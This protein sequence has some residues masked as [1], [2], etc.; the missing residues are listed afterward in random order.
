LEE[1]NRAALELMQ[2]YPEYFGEGS[3]EWKDGELILDETAMEEAK[4]AEREKVADAYAA[5]SMADAGAKAARAQAN[6][7]EAKRD[8]RDAMG[9]GDGDMAWK[10]VG[11]IAGAI[12]NPFAAVI[13]GLSIGKDIA[14]AV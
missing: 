8:Q 10:A 13:G 1:A 6:K 5:S 12:V 3:Y 9:I 7:T 2:N 11:T 14:E 4:K